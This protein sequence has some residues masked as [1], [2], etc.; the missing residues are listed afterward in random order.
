MSTICRDCGNSNFRTSHFRLEDVLRLLLLQYPV[1]C[2]VCEK[3]SFI[4]I[5]QVSKIKRDAQKRHRR[6]K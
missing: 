3:R 5:W 1:R 4:F 2:R 6:A